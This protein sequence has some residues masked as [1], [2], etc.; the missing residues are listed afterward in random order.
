MPEP[1]P[2]PT[3]DL[4]TIKALVSNGQYFVTGTA[5]NGL[6]ELGFDVNDVVQCVMSLTAAAFY[7]T[8][9][10]IKVSGLWQDVYRPV[11]C[12]IAVYVK[13]QIAETSDQRS[14]VVVVS[15]KR[16]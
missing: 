7:K 3:Y 5:A 9:P 10:A 13:L 11:H 4:S 2:G 15:F 6:G 16:K 14:R 12:G 8:M 1:S